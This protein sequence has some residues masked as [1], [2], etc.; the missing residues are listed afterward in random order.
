MLLLFILPFPGTV[1]LRLA[2]LTTAFLVAVF[3]WRKLAPP[4]IPYR[5][6]LLA[7]AAVALLSLVWAVDPAYSLGEI[8]N[9]VLYTMIAFVAFFAATRSEADLKRL[10]LALVAGALL[11][12]A[13]ALESRQRL[14]VWNDEGAFGGVAAF[15]GY[16]VALSPMLFL[17]G[18]LSAAPWQRA[19][20]LGVFLL[21]SVTAFLALQRIVWWALALQAG[22]AVFLLWRSGA[23]KIG[24]A[25]LFTCL[26]GIFVLAAGIFLVAQQ[27][28]FS[29]DGIE[30]VAED[31][32]VGHWIPVLHRIAENPIR[33]AG[34]GRRALSKAHPDLIPEDNTLF[35]H[36]HNVFLNYGLELGVPG[37]L[38]LA[39]VFAGLLRAYW[40]LYSTPD[41]ILNLLGIAGMM[42]VS[43]I[44]LR[45]QVNDMFVR[46]E[47]ILFWALNGALLGV[48]LR[49]LPE[50]KF[51]S[52]S[53]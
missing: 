11:I 5:S 20:V 15:A 9:E 44:L 32:R 53:R 10:L 35:W 38:A 14:G 29:G 16:T 43:G 50:M 34:F 8:K 3:L 33:G 12:C 7:W 30:T 42:L 40:R 17:L 45:N 4:R 19:S 21:V 18:S 49:R 24:R 27:Q 46:D 1:A 2:C 31:T 23:L 25:A 6:A 39:W 48:G 41:R 26:A 22:I 47:A 52:T 36:A 28:R 13:L 37:M 51:S